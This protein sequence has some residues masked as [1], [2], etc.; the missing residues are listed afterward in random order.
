[1]KK[2]IVAIVAIV[3]LIAIVAVCL[4]ACNADSIAKKL[5]NKDYSV[6]SGTAEEVAESEFG[7]LIGISAE[8]MDV[9]WLVI[10]VKGNIADFLTG[11]VDYVTVC[12]F[13]DADDAKKA[14]EDGEVP[15]GASVKRIGKIVYFGTEQ[16]VK[17]AM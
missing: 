7:R 2:R 10:G 16:G 3:A 15:E 12:K 13:N 4:T 9:Q 5:D 17:D 11:E 6:V 1:M 8:E 14:T